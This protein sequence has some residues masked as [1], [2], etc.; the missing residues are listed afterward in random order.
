M[1]KLFRNIRKNLLVVL[2]H[3]DI[4]QSLLFNQVPP[5]LLQPIMENSIKHGYSYDHTD[6]EVNVKIYSEGKHLVL[7]VENN[8]TAIKGSHSVLLK[9]GMGLT[10]IKDRLHNLYDK[11]Y[12]FEIRNKENGNGVETIIKIPLD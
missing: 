6:L 10:N 3:K 12:F 7:K 9:K 1:T 2:I 4:D 5:L 8:G 11:D